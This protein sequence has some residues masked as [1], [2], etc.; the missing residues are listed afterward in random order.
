MAVKRKTTRL[1]SG[2]YIEVEEFH[3][4]NYGAPGCKR[5]KRNK[6]SPEEIRMINHLNKVR[7]CRLRLLEYFNVN[8]IFATLTYEVQKRP[9]TMSE[10]VED[11]KK[12]IRTIRRQFKKRGRELFWIR[13]IERGTKGAWHIHLVI[14]NIGD[15]ESIL[16]AAWTKGGIYSMNIHKS[17]KLYDQDFTKLAN[18]ITKD[19]YTVEKKKDGSSSK[20]RVKES[21]YSSSRNMPIPDAKIDKLVRWKNEVKPK[22]GYQIIRVYEGINPATHFIYRRYTMMKVADG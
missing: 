1:R 15:T 2:Q 19:E 18:Y 4:G 12:A 7:R 9:A 22:K 16:A 11:F 5:Q 17:D 20:P 8:D 21:S 13:N 10:A 14:N 3:D 6:A